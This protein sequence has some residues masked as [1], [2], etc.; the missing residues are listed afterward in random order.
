MKPRYIVAWR[1]G[2]RYVV[3]MAW[4]LV[5]GGALG[6][7]NLE[8]RPAQA[9]VHVGEVLEVGL[10]AVADGAGG[11]AVRGLQVIL[12]WDPA[13]LQLNSSAPVNN[14]G[15][16]AWLMSGFYAD[17]QMDGL[18]NSWADGNAY[19]QAIGNFQNLA[20][21][22]PMGLLVTTLRF[23][24]V[25]PSSVAQIDIVPAYGLYTLTQVYGESVGQDVAGTLGSTSV[26][27]S[28][29]DLALSLPD[30]M[31]GLEPGELLTVR[32]MVSD[33]A[34]AINGV[35][36]LVAYQPDTLSFVGALPGD[37]LGSPWDAAVE[38]YEGVQDGTLVYAVVL[39]GG[40]TTADAVVAEFTFRYEPVAV[41]TV[42]NVAL[43]TLDPPLTTR[44]TS[45]A[46][47]AAIAPQLGAAVAVLTR[48]D[49]TG[50]GVI[51]SADL[52]GLAGCLQGPGISAGGTGCCRLDF[53]GDDDIDLADYGGLQRACSAP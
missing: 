47:G 17:A 51:D 37:G 29:G 13:A 5:V 19:Y 53:D 46:T 25:A 43:T 52:A 41:P 15:P 49:I 7:V 36:A 4:A 28:A 45:A 1:N 33:L 11:E 22:P 23:S 3:T 12:Q 38:A 20:W 10:Y 18:N 31:C 32:L 9:T 42:S 50:D 26:R 24:V 48:G 6:N 21:A 35:Q 44:L 40:S 39:L 34:Q 14:N 16:Y 2:G 8:L 27:V 30:E